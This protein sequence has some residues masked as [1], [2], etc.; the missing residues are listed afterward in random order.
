M[1]NDKWVSFSSALEKIL[2]LGELLCKSM[3]STIALSVAF[4]TKR[5]AVK[6]SRWRC[7]ITHSS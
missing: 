1:V 7:Y 2:L 3:A 6:S 4:E 5:A